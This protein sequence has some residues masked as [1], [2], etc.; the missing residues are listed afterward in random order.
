MGNLAGLWV[1]SQECVCGL[2]QERPSPSSRAP[3][4]HLA[5]GVSPIGTIVRQWARCPQ[6][7][8]RQNLSAPAGRSLSWVTAIC[9]SRYTKGYQ[10]VPLFFMFV[11]CFGGKLIC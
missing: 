1:Q 11:L 8:P 2:H 6:Q 5:L 4:G 9:S 10:E 7:R 3:Q